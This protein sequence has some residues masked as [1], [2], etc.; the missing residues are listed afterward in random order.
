VLRK[1]DFFDIHEIINNIKNF[2]L[3]V[4]YFNLSDE[5]NIEGK[6][7]LNITSEDIKKI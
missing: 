7:I 5:G 6:N 1:F 3:F 4:K 2:D